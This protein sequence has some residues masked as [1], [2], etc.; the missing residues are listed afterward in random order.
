MKIGS[1]GL[2]EVDLIIPQGTSLAFSVKHVDEDGH[3]ISHVGHT[4]H[5][6]FVP[7]R[8]GD[9]IILDE[10]CTCSSDGVTV[11]IP[12][13]TELPLA[14]MLWDLMVEA[15][16]ADVTR[17]CYGSVTIVDTYSMDGE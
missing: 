4:A 12:A 16:Q 13:T 10:C 5:M 6:R 15:S 3:T 2:A 17:L 9:P 14:T 1:D 8:G 11:F 7:K